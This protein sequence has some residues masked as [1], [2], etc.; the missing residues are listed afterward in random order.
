MKQTP[1]NGT[2]RNE[3]EQSKESLKPTQTKE[4]VR[5]FCSVPLCTLWTR[6]H[7]FSS[8]AGKNCSSTVQTCLYCVGLKTGKYYL[9]KHVIES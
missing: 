9:K 3:T 7:F 2:E 4:V 1:A 5:F 8:C 6:F